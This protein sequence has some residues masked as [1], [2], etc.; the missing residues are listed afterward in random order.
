[1]TEF[2]VQEQPGGAY[3]DGVHD[4]TAAIQAAINA[5]GAAGSGVVIIPPASAY[6][7]VT[8]TLMQP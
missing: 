1:M 6:Y 4:D 5:A 3:G 7:K 8:S 2:N